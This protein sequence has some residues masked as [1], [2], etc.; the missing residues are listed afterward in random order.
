MWTR[1]RFLTGVD[2]DVPNEVT[3][4]GGAVGAVATLKG[5]LAGVDAHVH[6]ELPGVAEALVADRAETRGET[7]VARL[8][9][10]VSGRRRVQQVPENGRRLRALK[11]RTIICKVIKAF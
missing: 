5:L 2:A 8:G 6:L 1:E 3:L 7:G 4:L 10:I 9:G 11:D